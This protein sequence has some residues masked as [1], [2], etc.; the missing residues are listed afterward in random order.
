M[1]DSH[2]RRWHAARLT[3]LVGLAALGGTCAR[4]HA[5]LDFQVA[6]EYLEAFEER[7]HM[8]MTRESVAPVCDPY[9]LQN[10]SA[11]YSIHLDQRRPNTAHRSFYGSAPYQPGCK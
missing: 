6:Q 1:D 5:Q 8:Q 3:G 4:V 11:L 2:K 9:A 10:S 7:Q